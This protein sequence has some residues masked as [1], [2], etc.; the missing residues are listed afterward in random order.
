MIRQL[1]SCRGWSS[2]AYW[3]AR[4]TTEL[5]RSGHAATLV[6]RAGTEAR[7][8]SRARAL[9]AER[10][11]TL[12]F[13]SGL[14]PAGDAADLRR[15]L[16][17][18]PG[19]AVVHVHRGKEHWLA[20]LANRL[21]RT[22]RPLFRT[23]HIVQP[24][25]AHA[26]NRWLY[27]EATAMVVTVSEAIRRQ[28]VAADL[29]VPSRVVALPGGVDGAR[30]NPAVDGSAFR[31][32]LGVRHG[33]ALVGLVAGFRVMKGHRTMVEAAAALAGRGRAFHLALI[34]EG[35]GEPAIRE[36]VRESGLGDR[37]SF[38]GFVDTLPQ[39]IAAFDVAVYAPLESDGMSRTLFEYL[40]AGR[41]V[42]ASRV[43]V[44]PE[45][46]ADGETALT[47]PAGEAGALAAAIE[48]LLDDRAL[49]ER[50][51]QAA[52]AACA[53]RLSGARIAERLVALYGAAA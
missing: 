40:A 29:V 38:V 2:D 41:A 45:V 21:S 44:V 33:A 3:A 1:V 46:L 10:I 39:A 53:A 35:A 26:L 4:I 50:L 37:V 49:R 31:A 8:M 23:R 32:R 47:V 13:G 20:A 11:E 18:L 9:G 7:V 36:A 25:R 24:I 17:W 51:G 28:Y 52:A 16:A 19:T 34:G 12:R 14:A 6:C 27:R 30:F 43:G 5:T 22:P 42:V 48:R 15:L